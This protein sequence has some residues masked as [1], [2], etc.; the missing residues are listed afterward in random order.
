MVPVGL[1]AG[2]EFHPKVNR[3]TNF[4]LFS[5]SPNDREPII[6]H[7]PCRDPLSRNRS[8][9]DPIGTED[10]IILDKKIDIGN[11]M[12]EWD[13]K[14][15]IP[16]RPDRIRDHARTRHGG[17]READGDVRIAGD[18]VLVVAV[19]AIEVVL[20]VLLEARALLRERRGAAEDGGDSP[21]SL[22]EEVHVREVASL[23]NLD[24]EVAVEEAD[25]SRC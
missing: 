14:V 19:A 18:D 3:A 23:D 16:D 1:F 20:H 2:D 15:L 7:L 9:S 25:S 17:P 5:I 24:V 6:N 22:R 13:I 8:R 10:V 4:R 21:E 12:R 11:R